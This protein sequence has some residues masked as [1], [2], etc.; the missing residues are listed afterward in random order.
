MVCVGGFAVTFCTCLDM[1]SGDVAV[2][3]RR[4]LGGMY[5]HCSRKDLVK[6]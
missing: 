2:A 6:Y 4:A 3:M 5:K 1:H